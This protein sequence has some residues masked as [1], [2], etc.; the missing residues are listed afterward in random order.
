MS[1]LDTLH[2]AWTAL[3]IG[4][5]LRLII[6][7]EVELRALRRDRKVL[8]LLVVEQLAKLRGTSAVKAADVGEERDDGDGDEGLQDPPT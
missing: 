2:A 6:A 5:T 7:E 8:R 1:T 3:L 4:W